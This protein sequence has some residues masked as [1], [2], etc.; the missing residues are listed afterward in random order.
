LERAHFFVGLP[1]PLGLAAPQ[2]VND[3]TG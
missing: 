1:R 3:T 2:W